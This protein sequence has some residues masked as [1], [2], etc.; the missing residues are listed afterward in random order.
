MNPVFPQGA[1]QLNVM[2]FFLEQPADSHLI[3]SWIQTSLDSAYVS[4]DT[5]HHLEAIGKMEDVKL[6]HE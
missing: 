5:E 3:V 6:K 4:Q 2:T 1:C